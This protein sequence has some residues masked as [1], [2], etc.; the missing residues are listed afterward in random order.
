MAQQKI[1]LR[2]VRDFGENLGDTFQFLRQEF[3]PLMKNFLL[4]AGVFLLAAAIVSAIY[5][6]QLWSVFDRIGTGNGQPGDIFGAIFTGSYFL[7]IFLGVAAS[8]AM[9]LTIACYFKLYDLDETSPSLEAVWEEFRKHFFPALGLM[10]LIW[11]L[12]VVGLVF[13]IVPGIYLMVVFAPA[14]MIMVNEDASIG[15]TFSRCFALVKENFWLS[16]AVY[17]VAY[18]IYAFSAGVIGMILGL[19]VGVGSYVSTG[20]DMQSSM[21]TVSAIT[22]VFGYCFY[23]IFA[24]SVGLNYYSLTER[25]D[26]TGIMRKLD[27]LGS[28][29][30]NDKTEEQY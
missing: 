25:M 28:A 13:C 14:I 19:M 11:L 3:K 24:I 22:N 29:P 26:G 17:L 6:T 4:I 16:F 2:K 10:I 20:G 15:E 23:V 21:A 1:Y 18:L 30:S 7:I 27:T 12:I 9:N 5:Q 8:V